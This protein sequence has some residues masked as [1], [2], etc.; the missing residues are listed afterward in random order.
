MYRFVALISACIDCIA[1]YVLGLKVIE[2]R[3]II[4]SQPPF[5]IILAATF[6]LLLLKILIQVLYFLVH[7]DKKLLEE[8]YKYKN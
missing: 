7:K 8:S 4:D 3:S 1:A 2:A 6:V 5:F